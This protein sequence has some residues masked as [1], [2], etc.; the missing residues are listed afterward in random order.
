[1]TDMTYRPTQIDALKAAADI[2]LTY[3]ERNGFSIA[4]KHALSG[5]GIKSYGNGNYSVSEGAL[6][7]LRER[8]T[9]QPDF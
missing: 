6:A 3:V 4:S 1:M 5:R 2:R 8:Y 7:K 9:V